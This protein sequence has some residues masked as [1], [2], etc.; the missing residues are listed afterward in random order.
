MN[1]YVN[2]LNALQA[3]SMISQDE[4]QK[5][6][7]K[8][9]PIEEESNMPSMALGGLTGAAALAKT[10]GI[11][12]VKSTL[13]EQL[14]NAGVDDETIDSALK[15]DF[16][17]IMQ[18]KVAGLLTKVKG[19]VQEGVNTAKSVVQDGI[20]TAKG[21]VQD[22]IDTAKSVVQDGI[23]TAKGVVQ[24]G[25]ESAQ[26]AI[27]AGMSSAKGIAEEG[28]GTI[29]NTMEDL[30][31]QVEQETS[32]FSNLSLA[33]REL[34]APS[35]LSKAINYFRPQ[36]S[37]P[38]EVE[39]VDFTAYSAPEA[40]ASIAPEISST[41]SG[42]LSQIQSGVSGLATQASSTVSGLVSSASELAGTATATGEGLATAGEALAGSLAGDAVAGISAIASTALG[43]LGL[44]AGI[45]GGIVG[46]VE[47]RKEEH[48]NLPTLNPSSQFI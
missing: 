10:A 6:D 42:T 44:I 32:M 29:Q 40:T 24:E 23:D 19:T 36:V 12:F 34:S 38:A 33:D 18:S 15:G 43:P 14:K 39:M 22:G 3:S 17:E 4:E 25:M 28:V 2:Y 45:I 27:E 31:S 20:D 8:I 46:A 37:E 30:A 47:A 11:S 1:D 35:I 5:K 16:S 48:E 21:V 41:L 13:R 26:G 7:E 9:V